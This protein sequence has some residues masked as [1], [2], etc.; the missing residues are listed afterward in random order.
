LRRHLGDVL[1]KMAEPTESRIEEGH[2]RQ[3]HV[4]MLVSLPP[5]CAVSQV[6]GYS[7]AKSAVH[8]VRV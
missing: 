1:R 7:K 4:P 8:V 3:G 6:V 5:T 2:L